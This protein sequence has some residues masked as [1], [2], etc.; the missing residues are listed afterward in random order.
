[1]GS[2]GWSC[3]KSSWFWTRSTAPVAAWLTQSESIVTRHTF[4]RASGRKQQYKVHALLFHS[5]LL[6][7]IYL[8]MAKINDM[9]LVCGDYEM[10]FGETTSLRSQTWNI[11]V[12]YMPLL[13]IC[14]WVWWWRIVFSQD[15]Q[16]YSYLI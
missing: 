5:C 12:K 8:L 9:N 6:Y 10:W 4:L 11:V 7:N 1:M 15:M 2:Y 3:T 16:P 14:N 13:Y